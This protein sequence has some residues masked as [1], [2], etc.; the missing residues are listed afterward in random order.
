M[1][2]P[3]GD[4]LLAHARSNPCSKTHTGHS[5]DPRRR[6]GESCDRAIMQSAATTASASRAA[7]AAGGG[8]GGGA[9]SQSQRRGPLLMLLGLALAAT[10]AHAW[11]S[12]FVPRQVRTRGCCGRCCL[13]G[14]STKT[15]ILFFVPP[16]PSSSSAYC[17]TAD[18][19]SYAAP[20]PTQSFHATAA[21]SIGRRA[22]A[23]QVREMKQREVGGCRSDGPFKR[24]RDACPESRLGW[25]P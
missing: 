7:G 17:R 4:C 23:L 21:R 9:A 18:S 16:P 22:G 15:T 8:G 13:S 14:R 19:P 25:P 20:P 6:G 11:V 24:A 5:F 12:S 3:R 2:S 1:P 10:T